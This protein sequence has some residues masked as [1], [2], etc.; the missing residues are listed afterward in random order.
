M[1]RTTVGVLRGGPSSEYDVSLKTGA[2]V[3]KN[4]PRHYKGVDILIDRGGYLHMNG[5]PIWPEKISR[6]VDVVFNALH[7]YYGE[8]GKVQKLLELFSLPYTGS[9]A[10]SSAV[11]MNKLLTKNYF[12][13][14]KLKMPAHA[15]V[16]SNEDRKTALSRVFR[17]V[18]LPRVVKTVTGGSSVGVFIVKKNSELEEYV[19]KAFQYGPTVLVEEYIKGQEATCGVIDNFRGEKHYALPPIEIVPPQKNSFFDYESKYNGKTRE[20]CP[21]SFSADIKKEIMR[22]AIAAHNAIGARHYSRSDFI[23]SPRGVYILEINTLPGLTEESLLPKACTA[24]GC[25]FSD[26]L[27][28]IISLALSKK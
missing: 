19:E 17:A 26:L 2:A 8:D 22:M 16:R 3:L 21:S 28:H 4:L 20:L 15:V 9:D 7:G 5:L 23:V 12:K 11:G 14:H 13:K 18:S 1:S 10:F 25:S 24:V 27:D 6:K